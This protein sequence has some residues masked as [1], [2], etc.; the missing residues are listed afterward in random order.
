MGGFGR[1]IL[2]LYDI[3]KTV[4]PPMRPSCSYRLLPPKLVARLRLH[5][6]QR[7]LNGSPGTL[8]SKGVTYF[9]IIALSDS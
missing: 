3:T 2:F 5:L 8:I 7:E 6:Q 4:F 1:Q 9:I